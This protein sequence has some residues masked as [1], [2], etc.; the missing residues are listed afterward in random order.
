MT[1]SPTHRPKLS[2]PAPVMPCKSLRG[3][4]EGNQRLRMNCYPWSRVKEDS[5]AQHVNFRSSS[6]FTEL[7]KKKH[8][9]GVIGL[10][11]KGLLSA[12]HC[13]GIFHIDQNMK[14]ERS[15]NFTWYEKITDSGKRGIID[16]EGHWQQSNWPCFYKNRLMYLISNL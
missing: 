11:K 7:G 3:K 10:Q 15:Q 9:Q 5:S 6:V 16:W 2:L 13:N 1:K 12:S 4:D 8:I 14:S